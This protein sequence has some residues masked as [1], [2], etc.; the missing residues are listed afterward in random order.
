MN[1]YFDTL[2]VLAGKDPEVSSSGG[3]G[4]QG[5]LGS[6]MSPVLDVSGVQA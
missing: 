3:A 2:M 4:G 5:E 1:A 6:P